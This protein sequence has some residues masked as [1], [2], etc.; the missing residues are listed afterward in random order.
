MW[1][2]NWNLSTLYTAGAM[3]ELIKG[4]DKY[5]IDTY[6]YVLCKLLDCQGKEL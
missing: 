3:N 5:K 2:E 6:E 4:M 1:I